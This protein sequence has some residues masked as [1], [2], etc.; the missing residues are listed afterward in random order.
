M[1]TLNKHIGQGF[2]RGE[3]YD[4]LKQMESYY[5][6]NQGQ[7][8]FVDSSTGSDC[9]SGE[10]WDNAFA[11]L[12]HAISTSNAKRSGYMRNT[13]FCRG[14]FTE[15]L[16]T[17]PSKCDL[18]GVGATS[19]RSQPRITGTQ[20]FAATAYGTRFINLNFRGDAASEVVAFTAGGFE[21]H[22]CTFS[23]AGTYTCTHGL[24]ILNPTDVLIQGCVFEMRNEAFFSTAGIAVSSTDV[25]N[26]FKIQDC[27]ITGAIGVH[28]G[29]TGDDNFYEC[30]IEN[31][32][33]Y[34]SGLPVDDD[35]ELQNVMLINNRMITQGAEDL[36]GMNVLYAAGNIY[37]SSTDTRT[38]PFATTS[39]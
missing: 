30:S 24:T 19:A 16:T 17:A 28:L 38:F 23:H 26:R 14:K 18:I 33:I 7:V 8:Y 1:V 37:T 4:Y 29:V 3:L 5:L 27:K 10:D 32:F 22:N 35:T 39:A 9:N 25:I 34:S 20:A 36:T 11:T 21:M 31:C 6:T 2:A 15:T 13:I 12:E